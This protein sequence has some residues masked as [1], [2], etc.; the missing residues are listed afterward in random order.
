VRRPDPARLTL[1]WIGFSGVQETGGDDRMKKRTVR[2]GLGIGAG[3]FLGLS[4][5]LAGARVYAGVK[6]ARG[7][8]ID[9]TN[10]TAQGVLADARASTDAK[11]AI[12]C[13]AKWTSAGTVA[14]NCTAANAS[15]SVL[16]TFSSAT[17]GQAV[18]AINGD[19]N[20]TF[21]WDANNSCTSIS[22]QNSSVWAPKQ[23]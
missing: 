14:G 9:T 20:L 8:A 17:L 22:V 12:G 11:Q 18:A 10:R 6:S 23:L 7:V 3:I 16:C 13:L 21:A 15:A 5:L 4:L 2:V 1:P 19:S